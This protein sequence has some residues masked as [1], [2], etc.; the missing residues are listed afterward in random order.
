M[1]LQWYLSSKLESKVQHSTP[2]YLQDPALLILVKLS[3][4]K[5]QRVH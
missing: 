1:H 5:K 2:H 4:S 3:Q